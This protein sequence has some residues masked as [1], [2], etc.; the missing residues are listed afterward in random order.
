M[1]DAFSGYV[2][3]D[4][5]LLYSSLEIYILLWQ[6]R[7]AAKDA[8]TLRGSRIAKTG[9]KLVSLQSPLQ[10]VPKRAYCLQGH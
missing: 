10:R 9:K 2:C 6:Q 1:H 3:K 7:C 8:L 4:A 5:F